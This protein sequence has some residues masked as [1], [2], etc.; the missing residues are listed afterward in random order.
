MVECV[1]MEQRK[2]IGMHCLYLKFSLSAPDIH[3]GCVCAFE[4]VCADTTK[5][6]HRQFDLNLNEFF[7]EFR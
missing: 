4:C 7:Q 2:K 1:Q 5:S 6:R 3:F